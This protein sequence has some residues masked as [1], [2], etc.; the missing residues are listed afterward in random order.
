MYCECGCGQKTRIA[1]ENRPKRGWVK[2]QP[3]R[4]VDTHGSRK[5]IVAVVDEVSGC[6]VLEGRKDTNG[7]GRIQ[8]GDDTFSV[9]RLTFE[10]LIGPIPDGL[11]LDHVVY[12][13]PACVNP[14]HVEPVPQVVNVQRGGLT[15]LTAEQV[16]EI[17]A[18]PRG[19]IT[20]KKIA[21]RYGV[22]PSTIDQIRAG[23]IWR[24]L[25]RGDQC[26]S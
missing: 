7:Y 19:A 13:N 23:K 4:F 6:W 15:K 2:G 3:L 9:H 26:L 8:R 10:A 16:L 17:R 21:E 20:I 1:T 24:N 11:V 25:E 14:W 22:S 18:I 5:P 12:Q